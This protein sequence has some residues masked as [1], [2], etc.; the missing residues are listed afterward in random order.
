M[1]FEALRGARTALEH[2]RAYLPAIRPLGAPRPLGRVLE[3][4]ELLAPRGL[5]GHHVPHV[6]HRPLLA[7]LVGRVEACAAATTRE[8]TLVD[9]LQCGRSERA[10]YSL[11]S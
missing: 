11:L 3:G 9:V 8:A 2:D 7:R 6:H 10:D 4:G 1:W 5:G